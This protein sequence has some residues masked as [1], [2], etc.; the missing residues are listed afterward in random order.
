MKT[1]ISELEQHK[2]VIEGLADCSD[3]IEAAGALLIK[4]LNQG[5][6]ILLC[7]NGGSAADCQHIAAELVVQYQKS[8]KALAAIA[9][10]TDSSI[11]TAHSNDFGFET[12][13]ARQIEAIAG[14]KDCL[15]AISTS[16]RSKNILKAVEAA[17]LR[18]MAVIG[19]TGC[20]GGELVKHVTHPVIIP[21]NVTARIQEAHILIGHWW[22]GAIEDCLDTEDRALTVGA[23]GDAGAVAEGAH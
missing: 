14:E 21:S 4:T 7:G 20:E 1:F 8:R 5:G 15:I 10:T 13:Y 23:L 11:L 3:A 17:R 16:G 12:V 9:L 22:C 6:K 19:L 18:G 2:A